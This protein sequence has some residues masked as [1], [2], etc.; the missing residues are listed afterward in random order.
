MFLH[1]NIPFGEQGTDK[2]ESNLTLR[3]EL[4]QTNFINY[5]FSYDKICEHDAQVES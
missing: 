4:A 3:L 5:I 2:E 1:R